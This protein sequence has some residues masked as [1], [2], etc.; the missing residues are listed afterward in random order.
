[1]DETVNAAFPARGSRKDTTQ[2]R[3]PESSLTSTVCRLGG[4]MDMLTLC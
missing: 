4:G 2:G 3:R 1:M